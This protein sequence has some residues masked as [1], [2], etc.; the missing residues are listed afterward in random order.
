MLYM[1][2]EQEVGLLPSL[3]G[4]RKILDIP[5]EEGILT[6][7]LHKNRGLCSVDDVLSGKPV[8][9]TA[10]EIKYIIKHVSPL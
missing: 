9:L 8:W 5:V 4:G 1:L 6:R 10:S 7:K 2:D 3:S